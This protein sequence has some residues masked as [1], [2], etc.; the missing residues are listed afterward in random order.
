[1]SEKTTKIRAAVLREL[2]GPWTIED[3]E[4]S[5]PKK[6]EVLVQLM[7]A[8]L[9]H[10]DDHH[11]SNDLPLANLPAVV[12]HEG[13]GVVIA[14]GEGV[15]DLEVGD[16]VVCSFIPA[17][18]KCKWC[19]LGMQN[20]CDYG[21]YILEGTQIDG[22]FRIHDADGKGV[23][24]A[25][26]LGTFSNYQVMDQTS[27]IK[28][29]KD[30]PFEV[31]CL[32]ACG[33]PTGV[34]SARNMADVQLGDI[35]VVVGVG[36]IGIN[37]IQGATIAGAQR[38]IAVDPIEYKRTR[39]LEF[40]AT[41]TFATIAE[42]EN[43]AKSLTNGQGADSAIVTV[44][45]ITG[46]I[47]AQAYNT[48]RKGGTLVVTALGNHAATLEGINLFDL[49]MMQKRIQGNV[50]GGWSPRVAVPILLDMYK[51]KK[52]KL[53]EL[54]TKKY[55][56]EEINEAFADMHAGKNLRGVIIHEH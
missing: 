31:A 29:D 7:A 32:V 51:N 36:G 18:G 20:L 19:S 45:V 48:I 53:E 44:G 39:A 10:S 22:T 5:A 24:T 38:V 23:A 12:G 43:L 50:F 55:K 21:R 49:A 9:C 54:I 33:V 3:L 15:Y 52:L 1:M 47:V 2:P 6:G 4:L 56:L 35:V 8:G 28:I 14:V 13:A 34:G 41:D 46:E 27:V 11:R 16:H 30:V 37:A 42:A 26:M 25:A 40:G 17:C